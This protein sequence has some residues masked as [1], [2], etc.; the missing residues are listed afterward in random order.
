MTYQ[1]FSLVVKSRT[2]SLN[3]SY[4]EEA[5]LQI[6]QDENIA[7]F[8]ISYRE[9]KLTYEQWQDVKPDGLIYRQVKA[10]SHLVPLAKEG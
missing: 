2:S 6:P 1:T 3:F 5:S 7:G 8:L 4:K 9:K 10:A